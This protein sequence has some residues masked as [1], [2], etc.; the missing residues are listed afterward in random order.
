MVDI[1][2]TSEEA[3]LGEVLLLASKLGVLAFHVWDSRTVVGPGFPDLVLAGENGVLVR[4]LKKERGSMSPDQTRWYYRLR[5]AGIDCELWR[6][7]DLASG[8]VREELERIAGSNMTYNGHRDLVIEVKPVEIP[9][10]SG[11]NWGE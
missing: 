8:R 1:Y 5:A 6:P 7:S 3:L 4:E 10:A 2:R 9:D 11:K